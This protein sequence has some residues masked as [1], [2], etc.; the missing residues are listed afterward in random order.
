MLRMLLCAT[1]LVAILVSVTA[2]GEAC[3]AW[4]HHKCAEHPNCPICHLDQQVT[5]AT[6]QEQPVAAP[7]PLGIVLAPQKRSFVASF[8]ITLLATRAPPSL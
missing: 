3:E 2:V 4:R 1:A 8:G 6:T 7:E 5:A